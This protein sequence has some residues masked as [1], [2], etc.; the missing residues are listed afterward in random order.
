MSDSAS[1]SWGR[2][3][4]G[5]PSQPRRLTDYYGTIT[6]PI[7]TCPTVTKDTTNGSGIVMSNGTRSI[8]GD[9][10]QPKGDRLSDEI[11]KMEEENDMFRK[12]FHLIKDQIYAARAILGI[13][14]P[15]S[16]TV[17]KLSTAMKELVIELEKRSDIFGNI[18]PA[19]SL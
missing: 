8:P 13:E 2:M 11:Q 12:E 17:I 16:G 19:I 5:L 9:P 1:D 4:G 6:V 3:S 15:A 10:L 18:D 7:G 14:R